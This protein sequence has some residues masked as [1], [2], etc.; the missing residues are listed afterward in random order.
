M[1]ETGKDGRFELRDVAPGSYEIRIELLGYGTRLDTI[2]IE[3]TRDI[4]MIVTLSPRAI[5]LTPIVIE[6]RR[7]DLE[8]IGFYDRRDLAPDG[9][10][11]SAADIERRPVALTSD[12]LDDLPRVDIVNA[13]VGRRFITF[14][15]G[16][17]CRPDLF[18]DGIRN[19]GAVDVDRVNPAE[20][21]GLEVYV[22]L[23]APIQYRRNSCGVL[24]IWTKRGN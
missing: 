10:F 16:Y 19:D 17:R 5:E 2:R 22:G 1:T 12:L 15:R 23:T 6:A 8:R 13:G 11:I 9:H 7:N 20:I 24:L 4:D 21:A 18:I 3:D 14:T